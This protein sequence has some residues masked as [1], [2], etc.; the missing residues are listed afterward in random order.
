MKA[1]KAAVGAVGFTVIAAIVATLA[2]E[3]PVLEPAGLICL[4]GFDNARQER[5]RGGFCLRRHFVESIE[6]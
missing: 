5:K 3:P 2:L 6:L 4:H 1:I